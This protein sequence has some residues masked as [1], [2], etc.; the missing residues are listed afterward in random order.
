MSYHSFKNFINKD[1]VRVIFELGSRDLNDAVELIEY[2]NA[3]VYAFECNPD[4]IIQCEKKMENMDDKLK[5]NLVF[6]NKAV[7]FTDGVV[8]FFPFDLNKYNN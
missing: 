1:D 2:Y 8:S 7:S 6:V 5:Q 4:C 3:K